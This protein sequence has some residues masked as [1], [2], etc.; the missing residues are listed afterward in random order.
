MPRSIPHISAALLGISLA[1]PFA[2][3]QPTNW[4]TLQPVEPGVGDLSPLSASS[5][6]LP[7]DLRQ[8]TGFERVFR[9]PG[10]SR[11]VNSLGVSDSNDRFARVSGGI[12]AVFPRSEYIETKKGIRPGIPVNTIFYI[13]DSPLSAL[14]LPTAPRELSANAAPNDASL[15]LPTFLSGPVS[16]VA[17]QADMRVRPADEL[18][19]REDARPLRPDAPLPA[20]NIFSDEQYRRARV[21]ALLKSAI[22]QAE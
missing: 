5:R 11:G 8:P 17:R 21:R 19:F 9:V 6:F 4:R 16:A 15:Q 18:S 7:V 3:A 2:A 13:G 10:S 14:P 12:T 1:G 22:A 20:R